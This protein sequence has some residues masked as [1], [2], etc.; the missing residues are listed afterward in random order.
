MEGSSR[1][2]KKFVADEDVGKESPRFQPEVTLGSYLTSEQKISVK[3]MLDEESA[4]FLTDEN[5]L[6]HFDECQFNIKLID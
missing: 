1:N 6:G 4:S 2:E 3:K 5:D